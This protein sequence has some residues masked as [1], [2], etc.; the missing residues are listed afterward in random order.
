MKA[1]PLKLCQTRAQ[2]K[3][4]CPKACESVGTADVQVRHS[5]L[6]SGCS[7][8]CRFLC[9]PSHSAGNR[10]ASHSHATFAELSAATYGSLAWKQRINLHRHRSAR[11][12]YMKQS[13]QNVRSARPS[14]DTWDCSSSKGR[15]ARPLPLQCPLAAIY[16]VASPV[17]SKVAT[18]EAAAPFFAA[19]RRAIL[20]SRGSAD[21]RTSIAAALLTHAL[22]QTPVAPRRRIAGNPSVLL[23]AP[24]AR[25]R[26]FELPILNELPD[27][28]A[29]S[30]QR[31]GCCIAGRV[32]GG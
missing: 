17:A 15:A 14:A 12:H 5:C 10:K 4:V 29:A 25:L 19:A 28:A 21:T 1:C 22:Q 8:L 18:A 2:D 7:M 6:N 9:Y 24:F 3:Y 27:S 23:N 20:R 30:L 11:P 31:W 32:L 13:A 26:T 16:P